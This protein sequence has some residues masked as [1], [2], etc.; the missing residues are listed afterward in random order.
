MSQN[1]S[2]IWSTVEILILILVSVSP[3]LPKM[4]SVGL[5]MALLAFS[6]FWQLRYTGRLNINQEMVIIILFFMISM[7]LDVRNI[8]ADQPYSIVNFMYPC[9][10]IGGFFVAKRYSRQEFYTVYERIMFVCAILSLIGMSVYFISP[11]L[12]YH[13]PQ[14]TYNGSTHRTVFFFNYLFAGDI[15]ITRNSGIAWEPGLFQILLSLAFQMA[16]QKYEGKRRLIR[17][18]VYVAAGVLTRS[19]LGY[20]MIVINL[21]TLIMKNRKYLYLVLGGALVACPLIF[22]ELVFQIRYKL[23]GSSAFAA[24]FT[25]LINAIK[26]TWNRPFGIGS[27]YYNAVYETMGLG[28]YDSY[29]QMLLRYGYPILGYVL[30]KLYQIFRRD[31]WAIA[32]ILAIGFLSEPIAGSLLTVMF[33]YLENC[34][35]AEVVQSET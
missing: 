25:P 12:I 19:T 14:Y 9:Y 20:V 2:R 6:V 16:I 18:L 29:T 33:Y 15:M 28:S 5:V 24:R 1:I 21:V 10:F 26:M 35:K 3:L 7:A 27:T 17:V 22:E 4:L 11:S 8:T 30:Y 13:F 31:N 23:F 34:K 32:V